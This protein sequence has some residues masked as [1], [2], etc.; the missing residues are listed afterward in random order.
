MT[1]RFPVYRTTTSPKSL[2]PPVCLDG[3]PNP[4]HNDGN[5]IQRRA[6]PMYT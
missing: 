3:N 2:S 4:N 6:G 5:P 1:T